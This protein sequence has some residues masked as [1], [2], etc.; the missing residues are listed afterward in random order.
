MIA[1]SKASIWTSV[2]GQHHTAIYMKGTA[3]GSDQYTQISLGG[4]GSE[5]SLMNMSRDGAQQK[6]KVQDVAMM[7]REKRK[8]IL[9]N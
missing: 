6:A 9:I 4:G 7:T 1:Q 3:Q 8:I 5:L 2:M